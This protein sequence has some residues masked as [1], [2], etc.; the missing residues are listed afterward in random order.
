MTAA[1]RVQESP[2]RRVSVMQGTAYVDAS[3]DMQLTTVLGSC[4]AAC[5]HDPVARVGGMNHFLLAEPQTR[6]F[7]RVDEAY[8]VYLMEI[9]ING[10]MQNGA[11]R[12]RIRAHLYGAASFHA[13]MSVIGD[14]NARFARAFLHNE[15]ITLSHHDL[16]G[17]TARRVDFMPA[18][19]RAR[20]R[21]LDP[22]HAPTPVT[23]PP[24]REPCGDV[25]LF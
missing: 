21:R 20:C 1:L 15:G 23:S 11:I 3:T 6:S 18:M 9:L 13:G 12:S 24:Q 2:V 10:M 16:G 8:G 7:A 5:L 22:A 4:V 25:E 17:N 19:G 14:A